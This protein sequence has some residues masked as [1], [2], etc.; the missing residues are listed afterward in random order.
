MHPSGVLG[1]FRFKRRV[2]RAGPPDRGAVGGGHEAC[3][4]R[5]QERASGS[6][7]F[8]RRHVLDD[9]TVKLCNNSYGNM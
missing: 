5:Q 3:R 2:C 6:C 9:K 8:G 7:V 1:G 4:R